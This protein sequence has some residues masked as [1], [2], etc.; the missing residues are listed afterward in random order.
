MKGIT[1]LAIDLAKRV[2]QLHGLDADGRR[3]FKKQVKRADL[4]REIELLPRCTIAMEAC[5]GAFYWARKFRSM[6]HVV[7]LISPQFVTPFVKSQKN[8]ANDA[9]AIA[10]ASLQPGMRFVPVKEIWQ[11][12]LQAL[13][14]ARD[15]TVAAKIAVANAL[16]GLLVEFGIAIDR[17][18]GS[19]KLIRTVAEILETENDEL[20]IFSRETFGS[21]LA[22]LRFLH[23]QVL[24]YDI[25]IDRM[26]REREDCRRLMKID[27]VGAITATAIIG[28]TSPHV[29]R[30]GRSFAAS[31]GLVPRQRSTG[32]K[33]ILLGI[34]KRGDGYLRKML[35]HGARA[36]IRVAPKRETKR[37]AWALEKVKTR[38]MNKAVVALA[39]R[40]ARVIWAML[41]TGEE[42][43]AA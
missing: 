43:K 37:A 31:L 10:I 25:V 32:G 34:T 13:H 9:E 28:S 39:N 4:S 24:D 19:A 1:V 17:G 3:V 33:S 41:V 20:S 12:D 15:L 5:G 2:F 16:I 40:N 42:Y 38:G 35:I 23:R 27:G 36:A 8:D 26:A 7:K 18:G 29:F 6:G 11:Q 21:L 22:Q 14:R 30:N